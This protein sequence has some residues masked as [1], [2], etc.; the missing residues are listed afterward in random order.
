[1]ENSLLDKLPAELR[2]QVYEFALTAPASITFRRGTTLGWVPKSSLGSRNLLALR[3]T[4]KTVR[5]ET[6]LMRY[7]VNT[8]ELRGHVTI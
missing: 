3:R 4:C 6:S 2:N 1:M 5:E 8:F 7:A